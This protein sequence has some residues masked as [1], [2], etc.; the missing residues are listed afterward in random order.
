[1][2][3]LALALLPLAIAAPTRDIW[4][5]AVGTQ[6]QIVLSKL[7]DTRNLQPNVPVWDVDLFDTPQATINALHAQGRKVICYFSAGTFEDWRPDADDWDKAALGKPMGDWEGEWWADVR[8]PSVR[9]V[10]EKRIAKAAQK[11]CDAVDP[12]NVDAYVSSVL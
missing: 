1:M 2:L 4:Q 10:M 11:G 12:D 8:A 7:I 5:P 9:R 3:A 6:W